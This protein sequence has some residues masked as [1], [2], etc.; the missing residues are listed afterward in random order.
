MVI[1]P[2]KKLSFNFLQT[3]YEARISQKRTDLMFG[4]GIDGDDANSSA[5]GKLFYA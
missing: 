2:K 3:K 4:L 1:F 5:S